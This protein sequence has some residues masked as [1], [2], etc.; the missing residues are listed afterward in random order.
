MPCLRHPGIIMRTVCVDVVRHPVGNDDGQD[1]PEHVVNAARAFHHQH[2]Q[3]DGGAE[4]ARKHAR[5]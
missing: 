4:H 1:D 3:R 5:A 2:H